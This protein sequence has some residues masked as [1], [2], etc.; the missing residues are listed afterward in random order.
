MGRIFNVAVIT[1]GLAAAAAGDVD[2]DLTHGG[3]RVPSGSRDESL[4]DQDDAILLELNNEIS[5]RRTVITDPVS[6]LSNQTATDHE[7]VGEILGAAAAQHAGST[8][9]KAIY[10][11]LNVRAVLRLLLFDDGEL[12]GFHPQPGPAGGMFSHPF[13]PPLVGFRGGGG[14][15]AS[16]SPIGEPQVIPEP[17]TALLAVAAGLA[18]VHRRRRDRPITDQPG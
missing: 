12:D 15:Q 10:D 4:D 9:S 7:T 16:D 11:R 17:A 6:P 14:G 5:R 1:F 8:N 2:T 13:A 18:L 3:G